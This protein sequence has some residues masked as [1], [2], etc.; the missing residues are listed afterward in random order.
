[1]VTSPRPPY[2]V[3]IGGLNRN[4]LQHNPHGKGVGG[5]STTVLVTNVNVIH[6]NLHKEIIMCA[7]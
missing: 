6:Y 5:V 7:Q 4:V 3:F 2:P 1:M